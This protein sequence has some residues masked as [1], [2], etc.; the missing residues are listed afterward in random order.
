MSDKNKKV[1]D[2]GIPSKK[3]RLNEQDES[4]KYEKGSAKVTLADLNQITFKN[5]QAK[6]LIDLAKEKERAANKPNTT[7]KPTSAK[8]LQFGGTRLGGSRMKLHRKKN[9]R[10]T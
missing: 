10:S 5:A 2:N 3:K 9:N 7:N 6:K 4:N 1:D 8:L